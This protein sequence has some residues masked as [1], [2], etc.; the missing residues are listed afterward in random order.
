MKLRKPLG[1]HETAS[2]LHA[3]ARLMR[4]AFGIAPCLL[5]LLCGMSTNASANTPGQHS[6]S[7]N[8]QDSDG[9]IVSYNV[10]RGTAPGVCSGTPTP[11]ATSASKSYVDSS[12]TAGTQ[13]TYA[14]S[15]VNAAGGESACSAEAQVAV[16]S[17]P[18]TPTG[19]QGQAK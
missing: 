16:P 14:V 18:Q 2:R 17:S 7:L 9:T 3:G 13:Y 15:G 8:W 19:L 12:V 6:V 1:S 10:Y 11:Y 5:L 4:Q